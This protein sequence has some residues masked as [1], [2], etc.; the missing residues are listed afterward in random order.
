[1]QTKIELYNNTLSIRK[2]W[3]VSNKGYAH[4]CDVYHVQDKDKLFGEDRFDSYTMKE[5]LDAKYDKLDIKEVISHKNYLYTIQKC[6]FGIS[7]QKYK[8]LFDWTLGLYSSKRY[9]LRFI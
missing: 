7:V 3:D 8:E 1:M 4:M 9:E 6:D 2:S 5:F